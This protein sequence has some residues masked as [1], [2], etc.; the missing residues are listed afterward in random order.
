MSS[1]MHAEAPPRSGSRPHSVSRRW[2]AA[3]SG[4]KLSL[5]GLRSPARAP[6]SVSGGYC[7]V[8]ALANIPE[9]IQHPRGLSLVGPWSVLHG[10]HLTLT[11]SEDIPANGHGGPTTLA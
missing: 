2:N 1:T 7:P 9:A 5:R 10:P 4:S 6:R 3:P 11:A 8:R